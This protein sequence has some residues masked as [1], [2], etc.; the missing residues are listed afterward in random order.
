MSFKEK[1]P[2][3]IQAMTQLVPR[4]LEV[5]MPTLPFGKLTVFIV[6]ED[7]TNQ[8][9][10]RTFILSETEISL[11]RNWKLF[12]SLMEICLDLF[13]VSLPVI[14]ILDDFSVS[15]GV[16][17]I[18]EVERPFKRNRSSPKTFVF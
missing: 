3:V 16:Y 9:K 12:E 7:G 15:K 18:L 10:N 1:T 13:N 14:L 11:F 6:P 2:G 5:T 4:L 17:K 8:Q